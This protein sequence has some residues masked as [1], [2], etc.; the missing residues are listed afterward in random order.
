MW[1]SE[2]RGRGTW[3]L[4][5]SCIFTLFLCVY[6]AIHL[7]V[8]PQHESSFVFYMRKTKWVLIA[9]LAPEIV[10]YSAW[11]QWRSARDHGKSMELLRK[12]AQ[13][14]DSAPGWNQTAAEMVCF[15]ST[16][17]PK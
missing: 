3:S 1:V 7:N 9:L 8:P 6:T 16:Y 13:G 4:L 2:P 10:L 14:K 12:I 17:Y 11:L 5:Y 15:S